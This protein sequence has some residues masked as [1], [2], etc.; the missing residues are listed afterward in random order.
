MSIPEDVVPTTSVNEAY[1]PHQKYL[2]SL[3]VPGYEGD[4]FHSAGGHFIG[5]DGFIVPNSFA[6]MESEHPNYVRSWVSRRT[7]RHP[8]D[9]IVEDWTSDLSLHMRTLPEVSKWRDRGFVDVIDVFNPWSS[10]G[11]SA[12]RFFGYVNRCLG[13]KYMTMGTKQSKDALFNVSFSLDVD[14]SLGDDQIVETFE[15]YVHDNSKAL[16]DHHDKQEADIY[17]KLFADRFVA[18]VEDQRP[19]L[20]PTLE[21]IMR[22]DRVHEAMTMLNISSSEFQRQRRVL[23]G[24]GSAFMKGRGK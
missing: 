19:E 7:K 11:A 18:Y 20:I 1:Y 16:R 23:V 12:R 2:T 21:A 8:W 4:P 10:Y 9:V 6:E 3:D 17:Q 14:T 15:S 13:N 5:Q 24:L 22:L